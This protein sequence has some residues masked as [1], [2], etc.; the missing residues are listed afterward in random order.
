MVTDLYVEIYR[1]LRTDPQLLEL[2]NLDPA[3]LLS[4]E[5]RI[6]KRSR[7]V[8][9]SEGNLPLISFYASRK[10]KISRENYLVYDSLI[11]F[12]T[13]TINN[14]DLALNISKRIVELFRN[15]ISPFENVENF[16]TTL[17]KQHESATLNADVYCFTTV[18]QFSLS[19][20][21]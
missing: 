14:V 20:D 13:Y 4:V 2:M 6:Q 5:K 17:Y 11:K 8:E 10:G 19:L 9:L 15:A 7:P 1:K 16:E 21:R 3:D 12:N 18:L